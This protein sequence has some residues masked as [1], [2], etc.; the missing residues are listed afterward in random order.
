VI[1][2]EDSVMTVSRVDCE[3]GAAGAGVGLLEGG[4]V[5]WA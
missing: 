2:P 4:V 3:D 1:V 5:C